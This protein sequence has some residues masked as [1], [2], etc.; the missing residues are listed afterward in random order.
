MRK[1]YRLRDE[2][3]SSPLLDYRYQGKEITFH[4]LKGIEPEN[5]FSFLSTEHHVITDWMRFSEQALEDPHAESEIKCWPGHHEQ[6]GLVMLNYGKM[7]KNRK[8]FEGKWN[9]FLDSSL[10][11][12]NYQQVFNG[13]RGTADRIYY[14]VW[15]SLLGHP[16][17]LKQSLINGYEMLVRKDIE[18]SLCIAFDDLNRNLRTKK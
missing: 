8:N 15:F 6:F 17:F 2:F 12:D 18:L 10:P 5:K 11:I 1:L 16:D 3:N 4:A 13:P 9:S 14:R 7:C